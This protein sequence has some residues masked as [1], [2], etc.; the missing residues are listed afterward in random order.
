MATFGQ[1]FYILLVFSARSSTLNRVPKQHNALIY[2]LSY[3]RTAETMAPV[4]S[5][6]EVIDVPPKKPTRKQV[7]AAVT[8]LMTSFK[9]YTH[10][11]IEADNLV[12][13]TR[14]HF[15]SEFDFNAE[16][17]NRALSADAAMGANL[18]QRRN[19][20]S[21]ICRDYKNQVGGKTR[22]TCY[23]IMATHDSVLEPNNGQEW[24]HE[25]RYLAPIT[26]ITRGT[27]R[28]MD[29]T[30]DLTQEGSPPTKRVAT[31]AAVSPLEESDHLRRAKAIQKETYWDSTEARILFAPDYNP[32]DNDSSNNVIE[33]IKERIKVLSNVY[34]GFEGWRELVADGDVHDAMTGNDIYNLTQKGYYLVTA[35]QHALLNMNNVSWTECCDA[36]AKLHGDLGREPATTGRTVMKWHNIF[37]RGNSFPN[38]HPIAASG[39]TPLPRFFED[40][41]EAKEFFTKY[42]DTNL[43]EPN[44]GEFM[45]TYVNETLIPILLRVHNAKYHLGIG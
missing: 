40:N 37:A 32:R 31:A 33:V 13:L 43:S 2:L 27:K 45:T 21:G 16:F 10:T 7:V 44:L 20:P 4:L 34:K 24:Y 25:I 9:G 22:L 12:E 8:S 36:S 26:V 28:A 19:N 17:L 15:L 6:P 35:L 3:A 18:S 30:C 39:R 5:I 14:H 38:P 1:L 23:Y 11:W 42:A 29:A 41:P